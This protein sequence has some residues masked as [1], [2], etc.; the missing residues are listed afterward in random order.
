[1]EVKYAIRREH[2]GQ[3]EVT[4]ETNCN[5]RAHDDCVAIYM[6]GTW[7]GMVSIYAM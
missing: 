4:R 5:R 1:M 7:P 2:S 6:D 3:L